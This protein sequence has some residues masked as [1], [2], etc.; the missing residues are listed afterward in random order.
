[1]SE[2]IEQMVM[3]M[4]A[5]AIDWLCSK[6]K[7]GGWEGDVRT[8]C[9][10]L[11]AL[12]SAGISPLDSRVKEGCDFLRKTQD[13]T[14]G[15][16][17]E[18]DG[19]TAEALR[20][21][22]L[23]GVDRQSICINSGYKSLES[24]KVSKK[25]LV[26]SEVGWVHPILVARAFT[27][28]NIGCSDLLKSLKPFLTGAVGLH[29]K[30]TSRAVLAYHEAREIKNRSSMNVAKT[31]LEGCVKE[32]SSLG[33]ESQGYVLQALGVLGHKL[34]SSIIARILE[35][36]KEQQSDNG[37]WRHNVRNTA[38]IVIGLTRLGIRYKKRSIWTKGNIARLFVL[39]VLVGVSVVISLLN[40]EKAVMIIANIINLVLGMLIISEWVL[41]KKLV[42]V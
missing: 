3:K 1:M 41:H 36:A 28:L 2:S 9:Y 30:Y 12:V 10:V 8:T 19:D 40:L 22:L 15:D 18:D 23:C 17:N 34:N 38:Q 14:K 11:Q 21:L 35:H 29:P 4:M 25:Y 37:S 6:Q 5:D 32:I 24:L 27:A 33:Y 20:V 13:P 16:W 39:F 31:F 7:K 42:G 26:R